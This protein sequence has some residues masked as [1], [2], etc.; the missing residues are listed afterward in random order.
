MQRNDKIF[1]DVS[2]TSSRLKV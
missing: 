2:K 1:L